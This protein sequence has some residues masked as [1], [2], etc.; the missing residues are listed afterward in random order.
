MG[1]I[2]LSIIIPL[3][4]KE[5]HI[6]KTID[7]VLNQDFSCFELIVVD[8]GSQDDS[9]KAVRS[10]KKRRAIKNLHILTQK[11]QGPSAARN[12]GIRRATGEWVAF[13]DADDSWAPDKIASQARAVNHHPETNIIATASDTISSTQGKKVGSNIFHVTVFSYLLKSRVIT[14]SV[15]VKKASVQEVGYFDESM[16]YAEDHNLFMRIIAKG[17]IIYIN[18]PIRLKPTIRFQRRCCRAVCWDGPGGW[19]V[20]CLILFGPV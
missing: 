11:N 7:S 12:A 3:Y 17:G 16:K 8:D 1:N 14:S 5:K 18:T 4:N 13:L 2:R 15:L 20:R 19:F 6:K 10:Y 9:L